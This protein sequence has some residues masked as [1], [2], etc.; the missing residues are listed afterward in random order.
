MR[1]C[2]QVLLRSF[3]RLHQ[4]SARPALPRCPLARMPGVFYVLRGSTGTVE[5]GSVW[6]VDQGVE[7][8]M[9]ENEKPCCLGEGEQGF[10]WKTGLSGPMWT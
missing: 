3:I 6:F 4:E 5:D 9:Q 8:E 10:P 1:T 7:M 2:V